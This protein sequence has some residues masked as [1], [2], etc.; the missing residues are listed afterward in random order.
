M[1]ASWPWWGELAGLL[2]ALCWAATGLLVRAHGSGFSPVTI[3]ALRS[4]IAA[5][6]FLVAWPWLGE[7]GPIPLT[8]LA[9]LVVSL[10]VGLGLGDSLYFAA[11]PRIGVARALPISMSYPVLTALLAVV[12]LREPIGP[13]SAV[14]I[15]A[16]LAGVYLVA[17]PARGAE[18]ERTSEPAAYWGG[19]AMAVAA[20]VS[21]SISTVA[22][23]PA[24]AQVDVWTA[25]AIRMPLVGGV[26]WLVAARAGDLPG[27]AQLRGR[28]MLVI[29]A[30]G[31]LN[32]LATVL[33]LEGVAAAGA[34]RT[35]VLTA[36]SPVFVT[37]VSVLLLQERVTWALGVGTICS[38]AGVILL[39][40]SEGR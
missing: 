21:W 39:T 7:V 6:V 26:L 32:V 11:I 30:I 27:R 9:L 25:S 24:L 18:P 33:F 19:V 13:L 16:T 23:G 5:L 22:L 29:A 2:S 1:P 34:A 31:L 4:S 20:A 12:L 17:S 3:N 38:V 28:P 10:L 14:G 35:A 36:T 15:G 8:A 37:P 40:L